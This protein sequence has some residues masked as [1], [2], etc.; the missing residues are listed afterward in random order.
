MRSLLPALFTITM[1]L[2]PAPLAAQ[3]PDWD[4]ARQETVRHLQALIRMTTVY[5]P[6]NELPVARYLDS[7]LRAAG[8][9]THLFEPTPG[10]G[11]LVARIAGDGSKRPVIIMGHMDVVGVERDHWT[12]YPFAA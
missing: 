1:S 4:A 2:A 6:G 12:V 11:A 8:I 5:P 9:E 7:T 3:E 10:R